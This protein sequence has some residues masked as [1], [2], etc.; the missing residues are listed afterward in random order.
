[1]NKTLS[2]MLLPC[3]ALVACAHTMPKPDPKVVGLC[4]KITHDDQGYVHDND[5]TAVKIT[6]PVCQPDLPPDLIGVN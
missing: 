4:V 1:M 5:K 2:I 3:L 6:D